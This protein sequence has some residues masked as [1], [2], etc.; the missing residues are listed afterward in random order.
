VATS[1]T[2]GPGGGS[3]PPTA[4]QQ[5][6]GNFVNVLD[7]ATTPLTWD[8]DDG[9]DA[10][11]NLTPATGP[12]VL[13]SGIYAVTVWISLNADMTVGGTYDVGLVMAS[14]AALT[15]FASSAP[16]STAQRRPR[17]CLTGIYYIPITETLTVTVTNQD[18]AATR[19]FALTG[20]VQRV[21]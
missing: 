5:V 2:S 12:K 20:F 19:G 17:V 1:P 16:A 15:T 14:T 13:A 4:R 8:F 11:L 21:T 10:L 9:P 6:E 18:G 3:A 7:G